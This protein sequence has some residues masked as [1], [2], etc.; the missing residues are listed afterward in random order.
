MPDA[1]LVDVNV[2]WRPFSGAG[3]GLRPIAGYRFQTF[4]MKAYGP[5]FQYSLFPLENVPLPPGDGLEERFTFKNW[6]YLGG[7]GSFSFE[8]FELTLQGD[9]G[10]LMADLADRHLLRDD[11]ASVIKGRGTAWHVSAAL[12]KAIT[13]SVNLRFEWDFKRIT[14]PDCEMEQYAQPPAG[15]WGW[16]GPFNGAKI[17]SDQ[18]AIAAY[19]ELRI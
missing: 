17:W 18:Q 16:I 6:F 14:A 4:H 19:A 12:S 2:E 15:A 8:S 7:K 9:Y 1:L 3:S 10:W 13:N 11:M 5:S